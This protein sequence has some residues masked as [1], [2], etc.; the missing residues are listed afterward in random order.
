M[1]S[2]DLTGSAPLN[3]RRLLFNG[4][5][6]PI[7]WNTATN[8]QI[9]LPLELPTTP[10]EV[11]A[12]GPDGKVLALG[13]AKITVNFTGAP[14]PLPSVR[15]NEWMASNT[16]TLADPADGKFD[17]WFELYNA[18]DAPA[19]LSGFR[20]VDSTPDSPGFRVPD[21]FVVPARGFRLVWADA[22]PGQNGDGRDLHVDF[23]L[24]ATGDALSLIAPDG[25][26]VDAVVFTN[27]EIGRAHV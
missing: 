24:G 20:L 13:T 4:R 7:R 23:K 11:Q 15:F 3:A 25:R 6:W 17:D 10:V 21:G 14:T 22:D 2:S 9:A 27:Q 19:D 12:I 5:E 16:H 18:G 26:I 8:R 1:C